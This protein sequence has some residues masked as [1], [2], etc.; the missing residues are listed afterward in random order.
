LYAISYIVVV[1][2]ED[3]VVVAVVVAVVGREVRS[4]DVRFLGI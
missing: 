4:S 1:A 2:V 3:V